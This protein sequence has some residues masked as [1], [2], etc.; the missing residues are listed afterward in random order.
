MYFNIKN[1]G[2]C[3]ARIAVVCRWYQA[4]LTHSFVLIAIALKGAMLN[5]E[6]LFAEVARKKFGTLWVKATQ[7]NAQ[8][9]GQ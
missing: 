8:S 9:A 5:G 1:E 7:L 4:I 3:N 2:K 6:F